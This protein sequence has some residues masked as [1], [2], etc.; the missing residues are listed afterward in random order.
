[1]WTLIY[2]YSVQ[3]H[4]G[5][6]VFGHVGPQ[7][8]PVALLVGRAQSVSMSDPKG[9]DQSINFYSFYEGHT[10]DLVTFA[11][12]VCKVLGIE[13]IIGGLRGNPR[14]RQTSFLTMYI[15]TNAAGGLNENY[16]VGDI[17]CLNDV[18]LPNI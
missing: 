1:M 5:R 14:A 15:V 12:R 16:Q 17:V 7:K 10:M 13:T 3:G 2:I 4:A 11:T 8:M 6:F 9:L 18:C